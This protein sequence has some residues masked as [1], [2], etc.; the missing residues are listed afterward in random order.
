MD[1]EAAI[2]VNKLSKVYKL[3]D[4]KTDRVKEWLSPG[5]KKY[6][7]VH[8]ALKDVSFTLLRGDVLGIIGKNG[9]GKSTLLKILASVVTPTSGEI[10][11]YG[12]ITALL[13]LSGGFNKEL[14]GI[15][16]AYYLGAIQGFTKAEMKERVKTIL[17][18]ADI[19]EYAF[20]PVKNY[21][22]GMAV[23]LAFSLSINIDPDIL[24][25]DEALAV[26]D[27]RFQQKC[28]R[29]IQ[30]F[31][32]AGKTILI[33]THSIN[34]LKEFCT[35]AIWLDNG[36]VRAEGNPAYVADEYSQYMS[37]SNIAVHRISSF[38][39]NELNSKFIPEQFSHEPWL[40]LSLFDS[41]KAGTLQIISAL[42]KNNTD[43][44]R[45]HTV[46]GGDDIS[47]YFLVSSKKAVQKV[48]VSLFV[49]SIFGSNLIKINNVQYA[50]R[51]SIPGGDKPCLISLKF[52]FPHLS[53][54]KYSVS[55]EI[56]SSKDH[57]EVCYHL[58]N[59]AIILEVIYI[60]PNY[61]TDA[62]LAIPTAQFQVHSS[63][64]EISAL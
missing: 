32:D 51:I 22:S 59:D 63:L 17:D 23:R 21:S 56:K 54:G 61:Q 5:R 33:C 64:N 2:V 58:T 44:K 12:R 36:E 52:Q 11:T 10:T 31:M 26:G 39:A 37:A 49:K 15:E 18:F 50:Q 24:I 30:E 48:I 9:S 38:V 6:H 13:E 25:T 8:H 28:F 53:K 4:S 45:L 40:D 57:N 47:V 46:L 29:K 16:N 7:K 62:V 27:L 41:K 35:R 14:T 43:N 60:Q 42:W 55:F 1:R 34:V 3:Y 20:Q 19:G